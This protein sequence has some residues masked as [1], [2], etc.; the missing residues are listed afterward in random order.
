MTHYTYRSLWT[1]AASLPSEQCFKHDTAHAVL[2]TQLAQSIRHASGVH[3]PYPTLRPCRCRCRPAFSLTGP[4]QFTR[5][6]LHPTIHPHPTANPFPIRHLPS[7]LH[8]NLQPHLTALPHGFPIHATILI[9]I[10]T[11]IS[12]RVLHLIHTPALIPILAPGPFPIHMPFPAPIP[13]LLPPLVPPHLFLFSSYS[14]PEL[15]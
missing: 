7:E 6:H 2:D 5:S 14:T 15:L 12:A 3:L 10:L 13:T 1:P 8:P 11:A 9:P 4:V